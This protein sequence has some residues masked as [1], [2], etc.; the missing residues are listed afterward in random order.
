MEDENSRRVFKADTAV[1]TTS[2]EGQKIEHLAV[3]DV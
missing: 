3:L 1:C 2:R